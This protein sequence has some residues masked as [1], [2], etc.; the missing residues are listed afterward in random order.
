MT[1][2]G[3]NA[4]LAL[5][6]TVG[7]N[8]LGILTVPF[9]VKLILASED[10]NLDA[11]S[12]LL[13]LLITIL[14]PLCFGK[15]L[16]H[17]NKKLAQFAK[18][19]KQK[20]SM[21]NSLCLILIVWQTLSK[22]QPQVIDQKA[23]DL[24]LLIAG[25]IGIHLVFLMVNFFFISLLRME[26]EEYRAVLLCSS[27]KT[28]PIAVTVINFLPEPYEGYHGLLV[29]PCVVSHLVQIL[30]DSVIVSHWAGG[31]LGSR[32][33]ETRKASWESKRKR[34]NSR[35]N[36]VELVETVNSLKEQKVDPMQNSF[37]ERVGVKAPRPRATRY[38]T[39][40][41][42]RIRRAAAARAPSRSRYRSSW[43]TFSGKKRR[44]GRVE[45]REGDTP[46]T[47]AQKV[48][49]KHSLSYTSPHHLVI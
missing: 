28:L 40:L 29:V 37:G 47:H 46:Q 2:G 26:T 14:T 24:L 33:K 4:A 48:N 35:L 21:A 27:Q 30:I 36:L 16:R 3:G 9:A 38:G 32:G 25:G 41:Q 1:A 15:A 42:A 49:V 45:T 22:A 34:T 18:E 6:L 19:Q 12:L 8:L 43:W 39:S 31:G 17:S 10:F 11:L 5:L 44:A 23:G 13:K 20:F 7:S